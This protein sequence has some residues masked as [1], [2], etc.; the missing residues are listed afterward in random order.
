[1]NKEFFEALEALSKEK[2]IPRETLAEKIEADDA[3]LAKCTIKTAFMPKV[4]F[5]RSSS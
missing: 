5:S 3:L 2:S 1:M 4:T